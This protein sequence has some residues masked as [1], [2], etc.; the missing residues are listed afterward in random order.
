MLSSKNDLIKRN[1]VAKTT[2]EGRTYLSTSS[3]A[4][5]LIFFANIQKSLLSLAFNHYVLNFIFFTTFAQVLY[6]T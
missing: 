3:N 1:A 4:S 5:I 6:V 2:K